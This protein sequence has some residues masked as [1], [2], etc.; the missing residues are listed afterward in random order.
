MDTPVLLIHFNRPEST[1][2]QIEALS[3][4]RPKTVWVL[5]DGARPE[6]AGEAKAVE[7][8]RGLFAKLPWDC[9]P[10]LVRRETNFGLRRN[11][12]EGLSDFLEVCGE[13]IVLEDD[14]IPDPSFFR[15]CAEMLD[16][17]RDDPR[18]FAI[19]G[20]TGFGG[21][22]EIPASYG[23]SNYFS[24]WGW[25][26]WKRAWARYDGEMEAYRNPETWR[27][28]ERRI[29]P[30]LRQRLY[31]RMIFNRVLRGKTESWAYR[32]QLTQW[33]NEGLA[34]FPKANLVEN[35][36]FETDATNTAGMKERK[37]P[38]GGLDFPLEHPDRV[39]A[40]ANLD[41]WIEDH[42]HSKSYSVRMRWAA[43]KIRGWIGRPL[44]G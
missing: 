2:R 3:K 4:V 12:A 18:I 13:G 22:C 17:Y 41:R 43:G 6:R 42:W 11:I 31:W 14:C 10:N 28:I 5:S 30:K 21:D 20:Y 25:A 16:R 15:F 44:A 38:A 29:H 32:F 36:G 24:C 27:S 7:E 34:V 40:D 9:R 23:F 26:T 1:R 19:S 8:V 37:I 35:V 39:E 33:S